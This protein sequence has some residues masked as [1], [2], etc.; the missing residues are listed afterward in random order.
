M[1]IKKIYLDWKARRYVHKKMKE[2]IH[3]RKTTGKR[4]YGIRT[5][6]GKIIN[7]NKDGIN[8]YNMSVSKSERI[9]FMKIDSI[10]IY[11]TE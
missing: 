1:G 8:K 5:P 11:K 10:C 2:A 6:K 9:D 4:I 7:I 3:H